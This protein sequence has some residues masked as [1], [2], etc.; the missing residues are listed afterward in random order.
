MT[1]FKCLYSDS[2]ISGDRDGS[3]CFTPRCLDY[4]KAVSKESLHITTAPKL[5]SL[6]NLRVYIQIFAV[7]GGTSR[8]RVSPTRANI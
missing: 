1:I 4:S 7:V 6:Y 2:E 8:A 5:A 3:T